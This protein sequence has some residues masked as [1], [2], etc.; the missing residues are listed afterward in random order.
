[1]GALLKTRN[2]F[3]FGTSLGVNTDGNI[4]YGVGAYWKLKLKK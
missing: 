3:L 1:V 2:D 4:Q